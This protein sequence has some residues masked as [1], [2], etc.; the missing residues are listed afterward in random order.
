VPGTDGEK[1]DR[2]LLFL[3][4]RVDENA[5]I[6]GAYLGGGVRVGSPAFVRATAAV[7]VDTFSFE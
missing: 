7:R 6:A 1:P 4:E 5:R 2:R 3:Q